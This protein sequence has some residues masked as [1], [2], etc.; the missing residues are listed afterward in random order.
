M[1]FEAT[2]LLK[3]VWSVQLVMATFSE[4]IRTTFNVVLLLENFCF[5]CSLISMIFEVEFKHIK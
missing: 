3:Y 2:I 5:G 4:A 1:I